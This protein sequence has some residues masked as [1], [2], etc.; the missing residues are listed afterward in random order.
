M[1]KIITNSI[2]IFL[3][4]LLSAQFSQAQQLER[5]VIASSGS[6]SIGNSFTLGEVVPSVINLRVIAGFQQPQF[7]GKLLTAIRDISHELQVYPV[8]TQDIV[9]IKGKDFDSRTTNAILYTVEGKQAQIGMEQFHNEMKLDLGNLPSGS[10]YLTLTNQTNL[11]TAKYK[12]L[13]IK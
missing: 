12:I 9:T 6:N 3:Y 4:F 5:Q 2:F 11:T 1:R 10:Y 8:P 7:M 13:K